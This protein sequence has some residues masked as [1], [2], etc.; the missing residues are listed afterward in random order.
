MNTATQGKPKTRFVYNL[1]NLE[2]APEGPNSCA[3]APSRL[4][5]GDSLATGKSTT[6]GP[7]LSGSHVHIA[8]VVKPRGTGSKLH[9]HPNEQFNYVLKGT[10]IA[11]I[12]GQVLRVPA[13]HVIHI[14][15]GM[16]HS[17]VSSPEED[18]HFIAAKDTRHGIVGPPVDGKLNGP[19]ALPGFGASKDNEWPTGADGELIA[20]S[21]RVSQERVRD[22]YKWEELDKVPEGACSAKVL[23]AGKVSGKSSSFGAALVGEKIQVGLIRKG[24]GSGSKLHTHPNEQFNMV[25]EGALQADIDGQTGVMV[26][27]N[28]AIHMPAGVVH[29]CVA[30]AAG[31]VL[32]FVAKDTRHGLAGP[33]IDGIEDGPRY[34]PGFGPGK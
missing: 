22:V 25:L 23:P 15:A 27:R 18:V 24:R 14:P 26:P 3:V 5:S 16:P 21:P 31:D 7:V 11:D 29:S 10:L 1:D 8:W 19:R 4:L 34:L 2:R 9:T 12:D 30:S 17:H 33:P 6:R 20:Q 13:G 32:F 28:H